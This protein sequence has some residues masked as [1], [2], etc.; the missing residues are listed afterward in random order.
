MDMNRQG[1]EFEL[2]VCYICMPSVV[3][4][5]LYGDWSGWTVGDAHCSAYSLAGS[6]HFLFSGADS[7]L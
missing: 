3:A 4:T 2:N 6:Q 5:A 7:V 1:L